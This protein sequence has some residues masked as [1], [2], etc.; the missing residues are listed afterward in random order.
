MISLGLLIV[1][2]GTLSTLM[3]SM[4][5]PEGTKP[6]KS[7]LIAGGCAGAGGHSRIC[8]SGQGTRYRR[9]GKTRAYDVLSQAH[10][11]FKPVRVA[12]HADRSAVNHRPRYGRGLTTGPIS[13]RK[14]RS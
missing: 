7:T 10:A 12:A 5:S 6:Y 1:G 14:E 9:P 3:L 8:G 11:I 13:D 4:L 2:A